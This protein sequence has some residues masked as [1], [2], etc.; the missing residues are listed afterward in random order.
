VVDVT[1]LDEALDALGGEDLKPSF[2][3]A[4]LDRLRALLVAQNRLAAEVARTVRECELTGAAEHDGLKSMTS[5]LCGH[6]RLS[7][8]AA[9]RTV[10]AGR[11]LEALPAV[12]A[13]TASGAVPADH[14]ALLGPVADEEKLAAAEAEGVDLAEVDGVFAEA[15][16]R[17]P[18][19]G[20]AQAVQHYL[21]RLDPDGPE[22]DPTEGRRLALVR[23]ADGSVTGRF[24]LD[25]VGGEK[26]SAALE[27]LLQAGRTAGDDRS[28]SQQLA[29]ALV[30]LC[31]NALASGGLPILRSVKPHVIVTVP[32][33]DLA[34]PA[35]GPAA[36]R[37][38]SGAVISAARA[39]WLACDSQLTRIVMGPEGQPLDHGR[40][41]RLFPAHI[42]R[43]AEVRDRGCVFT[44]CEAP[45]WWCDTHHVLEWIL[46]DGPTS[47]DNAALLCERH[48]TKVHHGFRIER[49]PDGRWR[50]WRPDG[51]EIRIG[52][53]ARAA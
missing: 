16:A 14:V 41:Q 18:Y 19:R 33:E 8:A 44:G 27:S 25:A 20:F 15:A 17:L 39:R 1:P 21:A 36:A 29:D 24:D 28:R 3:P 7:Q 4:L 31:D 46:D 38:G 47:L 35:T 2:G 37:T 51:T 6:G 32:L 22:P 40:T 42:R 13:A 52:P 43:A 23:H 48:H 26:L 10:R 45:T 50:T 53:Q 49:Q 12:A 30:Q 9:G 5:W 11:T 34:D